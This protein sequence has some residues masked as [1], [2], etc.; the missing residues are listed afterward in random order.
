M[1]S[2]VKTPPIVSLAEN[3]VVFGFKTNNNVL[4]SETFA[5][6]ILYFGAVDHVAGHQFKL[7]FGGQDYIFTSAILPDDTG[8]QFRSAQGADNN[9]TWM[10]KISADLQTNYYLSSLFNFSTTYNQVV[11][12]SKI[13]GPDY[14]ITGA[15]ISMQY[16]SCSPTFG[17]Y[18]ILEDFFKVFAQLQIN[19]KTYEDSRPVD[20]NNCAYFD[21]SEYIKPQ[22]A[23]SFL[24]PEDSSN[25][26]IIHPEAV[27]KFS[28]RYGE[29]Y[30]DGNGTD[31]HRLRDSSAFYAVPGGV[32]AMTDAR[33][34]QLNTSFYA[35][36][37][38]NDKPQTWNPGNKKTSA[39]DI[40]KLYFLTHTNVTKVN[41]KVKLNY[42]LPDDTVVY[43]LVVTKVTKPATIY[44]MIEICC[45]FNRLQLFMH[46]MTLPTGAEV[47]SYEVF[48]T[49]QSD[50]LIM[51]PF[52]FVMETRQ[53]MNQRMFLFLNSFGVYESFRATGI[54]IRKTDYVNTIITNYRNF[55]ANVNS[56]DSKKYKSQETAK[57]TI[58]SG[59]I[60]TQ[61]ELDWTR[62]LFLS[63]EVYEI[64][65]GLLYPVV[66]TSETVNLGQDK[67]FNYSVDFDY[68]HA[69]TNEHHSVEK[70]VVSPDL[71]HVIIVPLINNNVNPI[72]I[73]SGNINDT[74]TT[75]PTMN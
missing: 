38:F 27:K 29:Y 28:V 7:S 44:N 34:A 24:F 11:L 21:F 31:M 4:N 45:G 68:V 62:E 33:Y 52:V 18:G 49:D 48:L 1:L 8:L 13:K 75:V 66:I 30:S 53:F 37:C 3:P 43:T 25:C 41:L 23:C 67:V 58:N 73:Y 71:P 15:N 54:Q 64:K 47:I 40:Q 69:F 60:E 22:M 12:T 16:L 5:S 74:N 46:V 59:W 19:G 55:N 57:Y 35:Q 20:T 9:L 6:I 17:V 2:I 72:P 32:N 70:S 56:P 51:A 63:R 61:Q 26:M 14:N 65:D 39:D 36:L 10:N 50:H 42:M